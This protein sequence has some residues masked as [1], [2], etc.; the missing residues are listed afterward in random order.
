MKKPKDCEEFS[1]K[2][3]RHFTPEELERNRRGIEVKLG[4]KRRK[5][6]AGRPLKGKEEKYVTVS[7]RLHPLALERVKKEAKKLGIGY[8]TVINQILLKSA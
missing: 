6:R 7:I 2:N 1:F 3:Y 8:Q 4:I 5:R